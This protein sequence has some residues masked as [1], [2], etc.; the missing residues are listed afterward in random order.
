MRDMHKP[1]RRRA[2]GY[3]G[4][5][6]PSYSKLTR[7]FPAKKIRQLT[8][9]HS[10]VLL[11]FGYSGD[12]P[13]TDDEGYIFVN[14]RESINIAKNKSKTKELLKELGI[15]TPNWAILSDLRDFYSLR[16]PLYSKTF[17]GSRGRGMVFIENEEKLKEHYE[18]HDSSIGRIIEERCNYVREYGIHVSSASGIFHAVRKMLKSEAE[19]R[20]FRNSNN[21][22][23]YLEDNEHFNKPECWEEI[24]TQLLRFMDKTGLDI[25][26][27][28]VKVNNS[29]KLFSVL[30]VNTSPSIEGEIVYNKYKRELEK[31]IICAAS[32][33]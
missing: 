6:Q 7:D 5:T 17:Y 25:G 29:G 16:F 33:V 24:E 3:F 11:R 9:G 20:W 30:E 22:V 31:I 10:K 18:N 21:C 14:S 19:D 13:I 8:G 32:Q 26:R 4:I 15:P 12:F 27:F 2:R 28:D 23:F 1:L